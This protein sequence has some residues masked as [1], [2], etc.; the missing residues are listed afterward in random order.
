MLNVEVEIPDASKFVSNAVVDEIA[1]AY[2]LAYRTK[3][4]SRDKPTLDLERLIDLLEI[5]M[6]REEIEEPDDAVFL[7]SYSHQNGGLITVNLRHNQLFEERPAVYSSCLGHEIGHSVLRHYEHTSMRNDGGSSSLFSDATADQRV[8]HKS[9]WEQ[10]GLTKEE[11][12]KRKLF[13]QKFVKAALVNETARQVIAKFQNR[14][15]PEWMFWQAEHFSLCLLVPK[16]SL[17]SLLNQGCE[18]TNWR[19]IYQLAERFN[20][21]GSMMKRRLTKLDLIEIRGDKIYPVKPSSQTQLF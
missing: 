14:F 7:A 1:L 2:S 9:S 12:E 21:T 18:Y 10:Y 20:V 5:S 6:H 4:G 8:F 16:D 19:G 11:V 15:E 13:V 17:L 3:Y